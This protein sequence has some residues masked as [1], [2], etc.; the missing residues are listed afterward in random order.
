MNMRDSSGT[1]HQEVCLRPFA[2][3]TFTEDA[4]TAEVLGKGYSQVRILQHTKIV[5]LGRIGGAHLARF[6]L[7]LCLP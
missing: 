1:H 4:A 2:V 3:R 5:R 6:D 7:Q